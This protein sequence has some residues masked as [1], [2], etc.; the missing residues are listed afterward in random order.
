MKKSGWGKVVCKEKSNVVECSKNASVWHEAKA[1]QEEEEKE[2]EDNIIETRFETKEDY[3]PLQPLP[4]HP[5]STSKASLDV[6]WVSASEEEE[7]A[8]EEEEKRKSKGRAS[9]V[10]GRGKETKGLPIKAP[11]YAQLLKANEDLKKMLKE[12][13]SRKKKATR[14]SRRSGSDK[15][16]RKQSS[17]SDSK[18]IEDY[19]DIDEDL[20][21]ASPPSKVVANPKQGTPMDAE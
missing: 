11:S 14:K 19:D 5:A 9:K 12:K 10:K 2:E 16:L 17:A 18:T 21:L 13:A 1:R 6:D 15:T 7:K 8:R 3:G 20:L 4:P